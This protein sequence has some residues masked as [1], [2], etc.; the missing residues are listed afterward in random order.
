MESHKGDNWIGYEGSMEKRSNGAHDGELKRTKKRYKKGVYTRA[1]SGDAIPC[2][3]SK[4]S[5]EKDI[6][7]GSIPSFSL[8]KGRP[9]ILG[10]SLDEN[11]IG[12]LPQDRHTRYGS[13]KEFFRTKI[14]A[15]FSVQEHGVKMLSL[16]EKFEDL[17]PGLDNDTQRQKVCTIGV[18]K[19]SFNCY[20]KRQEGLMLE[21]EEGKGIRRGIAPNSLLNN[22]CLLMRSRKLSKDDVVLRLSDGK[23]VVAKVVGTANLVATTFKAKIVVKGNTQQ[24]GVNSEETFSPMAMTNSMQIMLAIAALY[25]YEKLQMDVKMSFLNNFIEEEIY[26]DQPECFVVVGE[27]QKTISGSS[28]TFLVLYVDDILLI[29][30]DVKMLGDTKILGCA[31]EAYWTAV[32]T[33]LKYLRMTKDMFLVYDGEELILEG[34]SNA[35]FQPDDNNAKSQSEI[36]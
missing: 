28:I 13:T 26:M 29:G 34:Y 9:N 24:P 23:V 12:F 7:R 10:I 11:G 36:E 33:I 1:W 21:E 18:G 19:G 2:K 35:N 14:I 8:M 15:G 20:S 32:N 3:G 22:I 16:V 6:E 25:D 30:N 31:R 4:T 17:K 27:E 5:R